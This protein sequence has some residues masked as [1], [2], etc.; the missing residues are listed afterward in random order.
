MGAEGDTELLTLD[1]AGLPSVG[2]NE[3]GTELSL[4]V[5]EPA[6]LPSVGEDGIAAEPLSVSLAGAT[7][8]EAEL[9][10]LLTTPVD[11]PAGEDDI[12]AEPDVGRLGRVAPDEAT[13]GEEAGP[14]LVGLA[15]GGAEAEVTE[16]LSELV[17]ED[18]KTVLLAP[19]VVPPRSEVLPE[20]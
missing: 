14:V 11:D 19:A 10:P 8:V 2:E 4:P 16:A 12:D 1:P 13:G 6:G 15:P 5:L 17:T 18:C 7:G 9:G 20:V 3:I